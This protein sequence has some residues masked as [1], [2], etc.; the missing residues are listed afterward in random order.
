MRLWHRRTAE[1]REAPMILFDA[2]EDD[3]ED[4]DAARVRLLDYARR[5]RCEHYA[6]GPTRRVG[7]AR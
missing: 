6:D 4:R 2:A 1:E 5:F 7:T 3:A